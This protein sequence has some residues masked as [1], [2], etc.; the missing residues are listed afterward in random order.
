MLADMVRLAREKGVAFG[1]IQVMD[2]VHTVANVNVGKDR[3]WRRHPDEG[4]RDPVS[5]SPRKVP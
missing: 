5:T 4:P 2:S 3:Q 1:S